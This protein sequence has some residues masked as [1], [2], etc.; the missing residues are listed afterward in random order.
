MRLVVACSY[1]SNRNVTRGRLNG[2]ELRLKCLLRSLLVGEE[3]ERV[4]AHSIRSNFGQRTARTANEQ[5]LTLRCVD[6][7]LPASRLV[8]I[9]P[10][11]N[12]SPGSFE[13]TLNRI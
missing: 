12:H 1:G 13:F 3:L 2:C 10:G 4:V 6:L 11:P 7:V 8:L 9:F 5:W